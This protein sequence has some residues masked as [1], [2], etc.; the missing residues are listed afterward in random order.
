MTPILLR[1]LAILLT[2]ATPALADG[3][4]DWAGYAWKQIKLSQCAS[5]AN[6]VACPLYHQKWDWKRNQWVDIAI[7]LDLARGELQ[8]TQRLTDNDRADNDDVCVTVLAVDAGGNNLIAHHQNWHMRHGDT[9]EKSFLYRS[10]RLADI[11]AIHIGSKQCRT[12]AT[13][14]DALYARVLAGIGS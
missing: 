8:L 1:A 12:G 2:L 3:R 10:G 7:S 4:D 5:D 13:Q 14:D 11:A 6:I 9:T